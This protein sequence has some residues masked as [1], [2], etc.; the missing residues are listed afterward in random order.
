MEIRRASI[1]RITRHFYATGVSSAKKE[2]LQAPLD[3]GGTA[4]V[5]VASIAC[6]SGRN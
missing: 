1:K 5:L 3:L 2:S 4:P 6:M